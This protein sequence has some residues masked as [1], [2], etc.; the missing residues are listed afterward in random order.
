MTHEEEK[1]FIPTLSERYKQEGFKMFKIETDLA[2]PKYWRGQY[3]VIDTKHT[4]PS[5]AAAYFI[6]NEGVPTII[7]LQLVTH[8]EPFMV[9]LLPANPKY[10]SKVVALADLKIHGRVTA[11]FTPDSVLREWCK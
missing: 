2:E 4:K 3:A 9:E 7:N 1:D 8:S 5:P 10:S 6:D 11:I